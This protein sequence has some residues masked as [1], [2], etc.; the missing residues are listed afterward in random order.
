MARRIE[1]RWCR[2][3]RRRNR[4]ASSPDLGFGRG[5]GSIR[6][7]HEQSHE[8]DNP[9]DFYPTS[10][11]IVSRVAYIAIVSRIPRKLP[12]ASDLSTV[13]GEM[14]EGLRIVIADSAGA[15]LAGKRGIILGPGSTSN[16]VKILLDGSKHYILMHARFVDVVRAPDPSRDAVLHLHPVARPWPVAA[17]AVLVSLIRLP[18]ASTRL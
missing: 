12:N 9:R 14:T 8:R 13:K 18:S 16:Q 10:T 6:A 5:S 15:R 1:G 2:R 17:L 3:S 11:T 4:S 7:W